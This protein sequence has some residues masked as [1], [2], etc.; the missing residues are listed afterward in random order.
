MKT[1]MSYVA[2]AILAIAAGLSTIPA[3]GQQ[4]PCPG[5]LDVDTRM[6]ADQSILSKQPV[7]LTTDNTMYDHIVL[8]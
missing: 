6:L 7:S 4:L 3:F 1:R 2:I 5:C 8:R